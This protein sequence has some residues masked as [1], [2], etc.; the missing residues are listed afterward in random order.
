MVATFTIGG[1]QQPAKFLSGPFLVHED[2]Q[3]CFYACLGQG[4]CMHVGATLHR[5]GRRPIGNLAL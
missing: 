1:G 3:M 2:A 5:K 4:V